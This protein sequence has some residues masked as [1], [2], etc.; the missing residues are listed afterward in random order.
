MGL[1]LN[2]LDPPLDDVAFLARSNNRVDVLEAL[3]EDD[4][5]RRGL[6]EVTGISQPTL[7]RI[8][9]GFEARGWATN[10]RNGNGSPYWLTPLGRLLAEEFGSLL[11]V[12]GTVQTLSEL[13]PR[14]PLDEMDFDLRA[15]S[16]ATI[17]T[18]KPTD[19]TAH[20]RREA[21]VLADTTRLQFLCNQAQPET[22]GRY[23]DWV[24]E[25]G[26]HLE[27]VITGDAI[28]AALAHPV[29]RTHLREMLATGRVS[30]YRYDG[31]VSFMTGLLDDTAS[32][33]PLNDSGVPCAFIESTDDAVR[34]W[35]TD[36]LD[37]Y[38]TESE[39]LSADAGST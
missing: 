13:P 2:E 30:I 11:D 4:R 26:G 33:V 35:V 12:A 38:R 3:T 27:A 37:S 31:D 28:D 24:V 29:M 23:R 5:T 10:G 1:S 14:L 6:H 7:G 36:T 17:T 21:A 34:A 8:L 32:I 19:A 22:V 15:L 16:D 18:P 9:E 20:F 39:P 25:D